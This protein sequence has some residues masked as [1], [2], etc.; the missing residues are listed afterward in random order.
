[1]ILALDPSLT[2][3]G[4]AVLTSRRQVADC[5]RILPGSSRKPLGQRLGFLGQELL[6]VAAHQPRM[7]DV[8]IEVPSGHVGRNRHKGGGAGLSLYGVAVG[9]VIAIADQIG[10]VHLVNETEWTGGT[11]KDQR[12]GLIKATTPE[13][14]PHADRDPG[15]DIADAI[16]LGQWWLQWGSQLRS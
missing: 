15:G 4:W 12:V 7:T 9:Y 16:A 3:C 14:R 1:M 11:P 10:T 13:Y 2:C 6:E 5:G 8:I